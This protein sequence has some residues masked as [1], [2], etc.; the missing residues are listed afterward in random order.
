[1]IDTQSIEFC[2]QWSARVSA[3]LVYTRLICRLW[4][5]ATAH[6]S[7]RRK[8]YL[9]WFAGYFFMAL[10]VFAAFQFVHHWDHNDAWNRTATETE[11]MTGIRTGTGI[12]ANYLI[13]AVWSLDL[14][15][16]HRAKRLKRK[17]SIK[18]DRVV[19]TFFGFMFINA[20]V[21][22]GPIC[23]RYLCW[24]ALGLLLLVWISKQK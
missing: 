18:V 15:R 7:D 3:L 9:L 22:F 13:L 1:M 20:T 11:D 16:L 17:P 8:E 4:W 24:P 23:Y 21:V 6:A 10:H 5:G 2:I 14:I 19:A 12:W